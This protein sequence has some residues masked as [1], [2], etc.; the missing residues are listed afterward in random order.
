MEVIL[1]ELSPVEFF[2]H[3][4]IVKITIM[5]DELIKV[6]NVKKKSTFF[7]Y[8]PYVRFLRNLYMVHQ[9]NHPD[10]NSLDVYEYVNNNIKLE[11]SIGKFE[12]VTDL[13]Y[14][15]VRSY[16]MARFYYSND[17]TD[18]EL[19]PRDPYGIPNVCFSMINENDDRWEKFTKQRLERGFDESELWNLDGTIAKFIYPRLKEFSECSD[20]IRPNGIESE[21]WEDILNQMVKGFELIA[22]D[23]IKTDEEEELEQK[24]LDLFSKYF[25]C[26]WI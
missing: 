19:S 9:H 21:E 8:K 20:G 1:D 5:D 14:D 10:K 11:P 13:P 17:R 16:E 25:F 26:L 15:G 2:N 4:G 3:G 6:C 24:A 12:Y 22:S 7:D 23:K 18:S